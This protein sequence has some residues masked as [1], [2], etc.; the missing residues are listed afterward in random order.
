MEERI[1]KAILVSVETAIISQKILNYIALI[2]TA[3]LVPGLQHDRQICQLSQ[4]LLM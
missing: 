4:N 3:V 2:F 1:L